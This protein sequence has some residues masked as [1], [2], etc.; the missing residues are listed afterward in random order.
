MSFGGLVAYGDSDDSD[1]NEQE[2]DTEDKPVETPSQT[3]PTTTSTGPIDNTVSTPEKGSQDKKVFSN[4]G[5]VDDIE[6]DEFEPVLPPNSQQVSWPASGLGLNLP[7]PKRE[8]GGSQIIEEVLG[9]L[10]QK[11]TDQSKNTPIS[12]KSILD[13]TL[14]DSSSKILPLAGRL[15]N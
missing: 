9:P 8:A 6:D 10:S 1:V 5:S 13:E 15:F 12:E 14:T 4:I 3:N 11:K 2:S 7:P